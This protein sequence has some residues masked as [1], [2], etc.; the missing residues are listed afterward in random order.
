M[1]RIISILAS[2]FA[3]SVSAKDEPHPVWPDLKGIE[4]VSGRAATREDVDSGRAVFVLMDADK[5]IG[6]P[7]KIRLPQYAFHVDAETKKRTPCVV[8]QAEEARGQKLIGCRILS[9][10]KIMA[11][12]L[13]EFI[14]LGEK[15][16]KL[17]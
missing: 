3:A 7:I 9:G 4:C 1:K 15:A 12:F 13:A 2:F 10:G 16:P 17:E 8:I 14:L 11:G 5:P 6:I